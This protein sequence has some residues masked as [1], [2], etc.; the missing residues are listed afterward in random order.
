MLNGPE[1]WDHILKVLPKGCIIAG[2]AIRDYMLK[3][4]PRDIDVFCGSDTPLPAWNNGRNNFREI[5]IP[6]EKRKEYEALGN[7]QEVAVVQRG[8]IAGWTVD[9]VQLVKEKVKWTDVVSRFDL[10]ITCGAY[11][12][13]LHLTQ[14]ML[15]DLATQRCTMRRE[16]GQDRTKE[17]FERFN[18]RTGGNFVLVPYEKPAPRRKVPLPKAA[19][20]PNQEHDFLYNSGFDLPRDLTDR[21]I[22]GYQYSGVDQVEFTIK[23]KIWKCSRDDWNAFVEDL[24]CPDHKVKMRQPTPTIGVLSDTNLP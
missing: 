17:R 12:G 11:D 19:M 2:G 9:Y 22:T 20:L 16:R 1:L 5:P 3:W 15:M 7:G 18:M 6:E 4:P 8:E 24:G 13:V 14:E 21:G 10:S 23:G